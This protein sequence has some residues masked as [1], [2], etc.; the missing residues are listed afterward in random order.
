MID[1]PS[2]SLFIERYMSV[3][4]QAVDFLIHCDLGVAWVDILLYT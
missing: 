3:S 4:R 2:V 1:W